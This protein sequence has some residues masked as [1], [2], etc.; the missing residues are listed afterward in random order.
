VFA[1]DIKIAIVANFV[2]TIKELVHNFK[3]Q[4]GNNVT[5]ITGSTGRHYA[6]IKN[7]A[8][9]DIFFAADTKRPKLLED[10]GI[11]S[12]RFT[13][14]IGK[15]VLWSPINNY[16]DNQGNVLKNSDFRHLAIA[17][18]KLAVPKK[19]YKVTHL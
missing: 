16:V 2:S 14:A 1:T 4:T 12:F 5:L 10:E 19:L 7:G 8:P 6:Q 11:A 13:Y 17:N 15:I 3:K 9:F 18:P